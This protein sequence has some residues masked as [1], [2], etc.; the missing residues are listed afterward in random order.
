MLFYIH[1]HVFFI[2]IHIHAF[3][4]S[5]TPLRKVDMKSR[6]SQQSQG[7]NWMQLPKFSEIIAVKLYFQRFQVVNKQELYNELKNNTS[8]HKFQRTNTKFL[9]VIIIIVF[10]YLTSTDNTIITSHSIPKESKVLIFS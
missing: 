1:I 5:Y 6:R 7:C 10:P 4:Y 2:L 3:L 9:S 8:F